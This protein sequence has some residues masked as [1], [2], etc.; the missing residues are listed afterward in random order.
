MRM[1]TS[2]PSKCRAGAPASTWPWCAAGG[3]WADIALPAALVEGQYKASIFLTRKGHV[4]S[5][6]SAP[7]GVAKVGLERWLYRL[8]MERPFW[9]GLMSLGFAVG[10]GWAASAAPRSCC[11]APSRRFSV[12]WSPTTSAMRSGA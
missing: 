6:Y 4:I 12:C 1:S 11:S 7:V 5:E 9:Y 2:S 10:A 8:A 3:I